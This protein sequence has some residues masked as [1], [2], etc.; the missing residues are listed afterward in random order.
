M[1]IVTTAVWLSLALLRLKAVYFCTRVTV[2][3]AAVKMLDDEAS[4]GADCCLVLSM[5]GE[6]CC[7]GGYNY[8]ACLL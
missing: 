2:V 1:T 7:K 8:I 6:G 4:V 3:R 5:E